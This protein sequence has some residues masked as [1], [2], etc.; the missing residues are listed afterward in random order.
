MLRS[1]IVTDL[2]WIGRSTLMRVGRQCWVEC[3]ERIP[4]SVLG[5]L[6]EVQVMTKAPGSK[7]WLAGGY[8]LL[9][10]PSDWDMDGDPLSY[11]SIERWIGRAG[12][13]GAF[14]GRRGAVDAW[15]KSQANPY[16]LVWAH[17]LPF[18]VADGLWQIQGGDPLA[19]CRVHAGIIEVLRLASEDGHSGLVVDEMSKRLRERLCLEHSVPALK[20]ILCSAPK[21]VVSDAGLV[22][23]EAVRRMEEFV[24]NSLRDG[25]QLNLL[26]EGDPDLFWL[27]R[28]RFSV[29]TGPPGSG[30]THVLRELIR[31]CAEK[32]L[33]VGV[34]AM[35]G[36]AASLLGPSAQT[37]HKLLGFGPSGFSSKVLPY[38]LLLVD[39]SSMLTYPQLSAL[40]R[41]VRCPVVFSGDPN[42]LP[43]VQ[44]IP[45][46]AVLLSQCPV[47][48][49][50]KVRAHLPVASPLSVADVSFS[51]LKDVLRYLEWMMRQWPG[52]QVLSPLRKGM[53]GMMALNQHLQSWMNPS[54]LTV[55]GF[56]VDDPVIGCQKI[57]RGGQQVC[58]GQMGRVSGF[59]GSEV[60][61]RFKDRGEVCC[62]VSEIELAYCLTVHLAQG[63]RF[64]RVIAVVPTRL[65]PEFVQDSTMQLVLRSRHS[66]QAVCLTY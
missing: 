47:H 13:G 39:E 8:R 51:N 49:L 40:M 48:D 37:F 4:W 22:Q 35:T 43:P 42:Q 55:G 20:E 56:R 36:K 29:L 25:N 16:F 63:S 10:F 38:D 12:W 6:V 26:A 62:R 17:V 66:Q 65:A 2:R 3:A 34:A 61:V 19:L 46:F 41:A 7:T 14:R 53:L 57:V 44:G 21:A 27:L 50:G 59:L 52:S 33:R 5:R 11:E 18:S 54:V 64:S 1:G 23:W 24:V 58:K 31:Y 30:K 9:P 15:V 45:V 60:V 28:Y 32:G